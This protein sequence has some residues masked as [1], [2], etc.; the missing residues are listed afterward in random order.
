[1]SNNLD[2]Y[3]LT[4]EPPQEVLDRLGLTIEQCREKY[5]QY[6]DEEIITKTLH[7]NENVTLD[8]V[9]PLCD[10]DGVKI[11]FNDWMNY[12]DPMVGN[13]IKTG[14]VVLQ[15]GGAAGLYP[16]I[17]SCFSKQVITFEP[18]YLN[19]KCLTMNTKSKVTKFN[20]GLSDKAETVGICISVN[21]IGMHK[22][23]EGQGVQCITI[24]SL[25]LKELDLIQLDVEG[26]E[27]K[28]FKGAKKTIKKHKPV[29]ICEVSEDR[30]EISEFLYSMGYEKI[31]EFGNAP[32]NYV[33]E[34]KK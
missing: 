8:L 15:A 27:L 4:I 29:I 17:F 12:F 9:W 23:Q 19:F 24:D 1:M 22:L 25:G 3:K 33:F 30:E 26:Y 5:K 6:L 21:N 16:Y 34:Y 20:C 32:P 28:V 14:G 2:E 13:I 31:H 18:E 11:M 10:E 7:I